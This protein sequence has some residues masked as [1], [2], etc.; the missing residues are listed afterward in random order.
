MSEAAPSI[1]VIIPCWNAERWISRAIQSVLDQNYPNL[2]I[3]IVDDGST[4]N[5]LEIVKSFGDKVRWQ[6]GP[7]RGACAARNTGLAMANSAYIMFLDADDELGP[8][9]FSCDQFTK[10]PAATQLLVGC[11]I[12]SF[13]KETAEQFFQ[14]AASDWAGLIEGM[15][16]RNYLHTSQMIFQ[17]EFIAKIGGWNTEVSLAQD[18]ELSL[19]ALLN[20]PTVAVLPASSYAIWHQHNSALRITN[21]PS[22]RHFAALASIFCGLANLALRCGDERL[23]RR[24]GEHCYMLA[25]GSLAIREYD[26]AKT[27]LL[28]ARRLGIKGHIGSARHIILSYVFGFFL[29]HRILAYAKSRAHQ[30]IAQMKTL[31]HRVQ[32]S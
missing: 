5:S 31:H 16:A 23:R 9:Y 13:V 20:R 11:R 18:V 29:K 14:P 24:F 7:N 25:R 10:V 6:T 19:R 21:A 3:I 15:I 17:R 32:R 4:D 27:C 2:E 8:K 1:S 22:E 30:A 26:L 28:C 12:G